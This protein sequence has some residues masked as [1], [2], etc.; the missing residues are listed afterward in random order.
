[1]DL[2]ML[3]D[4]FT[5]A[6]RNVFGDE[7]IEAVILH[8]SAHKGGTI[9]GYS[10]I[11][12]M[13]FLTPDAFDEHDKIADDAAIALQKEIGS[14]PWRKAGFGYPQAYFHDA[15]KLPEWWTGPVPGAYRELYGTLPETALATEEGLRSGACRFLR[16]TLTPRIN[17][18][19]TNYADSA[20]DQLPRRVRLLG[21]DLSP[22]VFSLASLHSGD[23]LALWARPKL[24]ALTIVE[25][26]YPNARGPALAR[27]F[28]AACGQLY[29]TNFD[30]GLARST[31]RTGVAFLRW[32]A[33]VGRSIE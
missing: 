26:A 6:C 29:G 16:E 30:T 2:D 27:E 15:R 22:A 8:G 11:D 12:F 20:D 5:G 23:L 31:F 17:A 7:R 28:Y 24:E 25:A 33:D 32:A 19:V 10:D 13:V 3:L 1:M 14:L 4:A 9:P 18:M 21:T